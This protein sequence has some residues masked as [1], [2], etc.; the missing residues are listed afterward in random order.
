MQ[1]NQT[2]QSTFRSSPRF[3]AALG[4]VLALAGCDG[5]S[6]LPDP[7]T[8][9]LTGKSVGI[10]TGSETGGTGGELTEAEVQTEGA[11]PGTYD[12]SAQIALPECDS[13]DAVTISSTSQFSLFSDPSYR[14]FCIEPGDYRSAGTLLIDSVDGTANSPRVLRYASA[15]VED[16]ETLFDAPEA[17]L[18]L[19]PH[20]VLRDSDHWVIDRLAFIDLDTTYPIKIDNSQSVIVNRIRMQKNR[21]G[22]SLYHGSHNVMVQNSY[23]GDMDV[24]LVNGNDAVCVALRGKDSAGTDIDIHNVS[25]VNN[26]IYNCNDGIQLIHDKGL[27]YIA[28]FQGTLIAGN[29]IYVDSSRY[30]DCN[31]NLTTNGPCACTE[32]AIDLKSGSYDATNPV[33]V[34]DNK[35]WGWR[36]TD[37]ICHSTG[38]SWGSAIDAHF[39][40]HNTHITKNVMWD[41]ARGIALIEGVWDTLIEDNIIQDTYSGFNGEGF[42]LVSGSTAHGTVVRRNHISEAVKWAATGSDDSIYE[43]NVVLDGGNAAGARGSG[44]VTSNNAYFNSGAAA[45]SS[46]SDVMGGSASEAGFGQMCMTVSPMSVP[47]GREMC[48]DNVVGSMDLG[49]GGSHWAASGS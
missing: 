19:M 1:S 42:A 40:V 13:S 9:A 25:I 45:L 20:L 21:I 37:R 39:A 48:I 10:A 3:L 18:A 41:N 28:D 12:Y 44:T 11:F 8:G 46:G 26:E 5:T 6:E 15:G 29:D 43:C 35:M 7:G 33:V 14:V 34:T 2:G 27:S 38:S 4:V 17:K 49:C 32:N 30:S 16:G 22:L 31:G 23:I 24:D 47:G 36:R